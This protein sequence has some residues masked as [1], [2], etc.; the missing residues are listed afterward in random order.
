[1]ANQQFV[2][3]EEQ[4]SCSEEWKYRC[5]QSIV[6]YRQQ[7]CWAC[8]GFVIS[9]VPCPRL[10]TLSIHP[11][12]HAVAVKNLCTLSMPLYLVHA[13]V[14]CPCPCSHQPLYLVHASVPC[15]CLCHQTLY[16]VYASVSC[17]CFLHRLQ[18]TLYIPRMFP[19]VPCMYPVCTLSMPPVQTAASLRN[20]GLST[21][22]QTLLGR[23]LDKTMQVGL[24][25]VYTGVESRKSG[26]LRIPKIIY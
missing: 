11:S 7:N 5:R 25:N 12:I 3:K 9:S 26:M 2:A 21:L 18:Q 6:F 16:L 22:S 8:P 10:C 4:L 15:S 1:M 14:P 23:P 24:H 20:S 17:P 19:V 13:S